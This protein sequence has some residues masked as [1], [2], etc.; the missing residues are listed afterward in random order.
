MDPPISSLFCCFK[1]LTPFPSTFVT[2]YIKG[3]I[4]IYTS[5][6]FTA[7]ASFAAQV[8]LLRITATMSFHSNAGPSL[9]HEQMVLGQKYYS[10]IRFLDE[11]DM[12]N[13]HE[14]EEFES[15]LRAF[16]VDS[17]GYGYHREQHVVGG[18]AGFD[19]VEDNG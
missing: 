14:R 13:K 10:T 9:K 11:L 12:K 6:S 1:L 15:G 2:L 17:A 19:D 18:E 7:S 3:G 5:I 16:I 4:N 8:S